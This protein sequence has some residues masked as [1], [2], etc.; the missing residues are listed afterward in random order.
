MTLQVPPGFFERCWDGSDGQ[1]FQP[2][3]ADLPSHGTDRRRTTPPF[4]LLIG[5]NW[6]P[7][8]LAVGPR[9]ELSVVLDESAVGT[10]LASLVV[11]S[12]AVS[13]TVGRG[14]APDVFVRLSAL[15]LI[16]VR[17]GRMPFLHAFRSAASTL[18]G[19]D[20]A[21]LYLGGLFDDGLWTRAW[22]MSGADQ[23]AAAALAA[24]SPK[25]VP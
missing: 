12:R 7:A 4:D 21:L 17:A 6:G 2:A 8:E 14:I 15:D 23:A 25:T 22:G 20:A 24:M 11:V 16:Q 19:D 3:A 10:I 9:L 1:R 18:D 5:G 13:V